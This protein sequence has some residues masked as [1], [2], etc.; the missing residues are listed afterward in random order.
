PENFDAWQAS[1]SF[2]DPA[3]LDPR[4]KDKEAEQMLAEAEDAFSGGEL[5][6]AAEALKKVVAKEPSYGTAYQH[7]GEIALSQKNLDEALKYTKLATEK[8][9]RDPAGFLL[10]ASVQG[11][12]GK[13]EEA[14]T[15]LIRSL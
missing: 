13:G 10:L 11:S 14:M 12:M 1:L 4:P 8:D 9:S 2:W 7:L 6:K 15:S 3:M 5:D